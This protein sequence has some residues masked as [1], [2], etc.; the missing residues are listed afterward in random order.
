MMWKIY[1]FWLMVLFAV[2][3]WSMFFIVRSNVSPLESPEIAFP[4]YYITFFFAI[5]FSIACMASLVWKAIFPV[6]SSYICIKNGL[7]EGIIA[8][9]SADIILL[10]LQLQSFSWGEVI[11]LIGII[12]II[13]LFF[14]Q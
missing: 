5:T 8:G 13:E 7:R 3:S 6:K 9:I 2:I 12:I 11:V 1:Q 10:F 14:I 4:L